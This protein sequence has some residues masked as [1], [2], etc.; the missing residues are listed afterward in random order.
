MKLIFTLVP[1]SAPFFM[2]FIVR[3]IFSQLNKALVEPELN[4]HGAMVRVITLPDRKP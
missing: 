1:Q 2:R 4:R 3:A